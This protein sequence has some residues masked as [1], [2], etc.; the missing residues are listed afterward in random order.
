MTESTNEAQLEKSSNKYHSII[1]LT[2][3]PFV[4][5]LN[6]LL[7]SGLH[8]IPGE[9][10]QRNHSEAKLLQIVGQL[11]YIHNGGHQVRVVRVIQVAD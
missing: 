1:I 2:I 7:S 6:E 4:K 11:M 5:E 10:Q 8:L 9:V 3:N